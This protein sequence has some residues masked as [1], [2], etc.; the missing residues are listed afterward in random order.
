MYPAEE[1][2]FSSYMISFAKKADGITLKKRICSHGEQI[3]SF[4]C[5]QFEKGGRYF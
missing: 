3:L 1:N 2:L 5:N 4:K